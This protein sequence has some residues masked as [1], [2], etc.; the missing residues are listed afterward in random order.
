MDPNEKI[1]LL[2]MGCWQSVRKI[3]TFHLHEVLKA[4][5][6]TADQS[7]NSYQRVHSIVRKSVFYPEIKFY[8]LFVDSSEPQS[9]SQATSIYT[10]LRD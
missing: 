4:L 7:R 9:L 8:D 3:H 6:G 2:P 10:V 5:T 1:P